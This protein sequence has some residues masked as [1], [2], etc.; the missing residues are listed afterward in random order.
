MPLFAL[1]SHIQHYAYFDLADLSLIF[2]IN[3]YPAVNNM[4]VYR[5][6]PE[7]K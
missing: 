2:L 4:P 1:E 7:N 6:L 3:H 5:F